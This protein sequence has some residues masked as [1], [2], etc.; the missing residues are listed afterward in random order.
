MPRPRRHV[1]AAL[2]GC[3]ALVATTVA[4][5]LAVAEQRPSAR[6]RSRAA[7]ER[8]CPRPYVAL[9]A[10]RYRGARIGLDDIGEVEEPTAL[11][12][13]PSGRAPALL[14]QREG[15]VR[16][17]DERGRI[18]GEVVLDLDDT[19]RDGDGGL[20]GLA[21]DPAGGWLYVY[22]TTEDQ[23][24]VVTAYPLDADG[25]PDPGGEVEVIRSGH[26]SSDQHHGGGLGFGPD[27]FLYIGFGDGGGLGD[28]GENAQDG[29][30]LLGKLLRIDPT[31]G[32]AEPYR[33]PAD[34]PY[35][36]RSGWR[37]EIW[38]LGLRNPYRLSF[39]A[40][41]GDLWVGDVGQACVEELDR[42]TVA[43]AGANLGWDVFE[44][45]AP[46]ESGDVSGDVVWPQQT[47]PH[48]AGW[49]ALVVGG[50]VRTPALPDL[51]GWLLHTDYCRGRIMAFRPGD[52]SG[53][54]PELLDTGL[55]IER[56]IAIVDGPDGLP[57]V[58]SLD[59]PITRVVPRS[60]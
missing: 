53:R 44:G 2:V 52:G 26:G 4:A 47:Y 18:T 42:L 15:M 35:V 21:Y 50:V 33:V 16:V 56:P 13:D 31:P 29:D 43:D 58:L 37:P 12:V 9:E 45:S 49:C 11:A 1:V 46:F 40:V 8:P 24:D 36:G 22:R 17:V 27:G 57:W 34:N 60:R 23:D 38:A 5:G 19:S 59:G 7:A 39:D 20:L 3:A 51:D 41:S 6:Q 28:P 54:A 32:D 10:Q 14:G 55:R 48:N 25:R 30:E